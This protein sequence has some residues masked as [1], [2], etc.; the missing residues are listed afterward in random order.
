[1]NQDFIAILQQLTAEQGREALLNPARCKAFLADYT[2][3]EYKKESRLLLQ[4]LEA[5]VPKAIES[6]K[7]LEIC[8]LQ[9]A[10]VLHEEHFLTA[11]AAA[12][13]VETLALVL[14][15]KQGRRTPQGMLCA[16]CG[17]ELQKEWKACPHCGTPTTKI[18]QNP[19]KAKS[20]KTKAKPPQTKPQLSSSPKNAKK[21]YDIG[22]TFLLNKD[23]DNAIAQFNEAIRLDPN[24]AWAYAERGVAYLF[25]KQFD[26]AINDLNEAIRLDPNYAFAYV[27][28]GLVYSNKDKN[29]TA[30]KDY[31]EAIRLNPNYAIAYEYRGD[32]YSEKGKYNTAIKDYSEAIRLDPNNAD[33]YI[34]R[35]DAY[36]ELGQKDR[37]IQDLEK[38]VSIDPNMDWVK[39]ELQE[40]RGYKGGMKK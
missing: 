4:A 34:G 17:K 7:E 22:N 11:E 6:T 37:A 19:P 13:V 39:K 10:R 29:N 25:K 40:I 23:Y 15:G 28:R 2:R 5:G 32:A 35:G 20:V 36:K 30:I 33:A 38:A 12:D 31:N 3:G 16:N 18:T 8:K 14:R 26:R 1:M 21:Y 27:K 24:Y 9:Q